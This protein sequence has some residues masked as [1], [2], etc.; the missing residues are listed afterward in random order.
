M[1]KIIEKT[2]D[3][4][5]RTENLDPHNMSAWEL[6]KAKFFYKPLSKD[7]GWWYTLGSLSL[8]LF[9]TQV[10]TGILLAGNYV[11][12]L[13]DAYNSVEHIQKEM[14]LGW[15]I[16]GVHHW[17]SHLMVLT[18]FIHLLR[19]FFHGGYKRPNQYIWVTGVFLL[20][21]TA[22][23]ALTGY[24]LP[25]SDRSYWA[26]TILAKVFEFL[27][28]IG[29][30]LANMVGGIQVGA[31]TLTRYG[32]FHM[33]LIPFLIVLV[34]ATHVLLIQLH[35]EKGPPPKEGVDVGT[36]PFFPYQLSK[37]A[38]ASFVMMAVLFLLA[39]YIGVPAD[40]PARPLAEI[41]SV[42]KPEWFIL[43]GYEILK[44]FEGKSIV[45]A[46]T[47]LPVVGI[48]AL[49]FL[50]FYD[51][52]RERAYTK[53]PLAIAT[54]FGAV[55]L[56]LY[57]TLIADVSSPLPGKFF[58][59]DRPLAVK[60][61]AG[62]ALFEKNVC[63]CCH[64]MEGV[65]MKNAPDLWKTASKRDAEYLRNLL[66]DPDKTLGKKGEMVTYHMDDAD[67]EALVSY[68]GSVDF[69]RY[70]SKLMDPSVFRSAHIIY[71]NEKAV[72]GADVKTRNQRIAALLQKNKRELKEKS[73]LAQTSS[74][75][76]A[77]IAT[78]FATNYK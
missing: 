33:I 76:I 54:G 52:N 12:T 47:V 37:D 72:A 17:G 13:A 38:I 23:M 7:I 22:L 56:V 67:L 16:R 15:L 14:T 19:A 39:R 24:I 78:Y 35:G 34:V 29:V 63:Y 45:F 59:P 2:E 48:A 11:P 8:F 51:K 31:L 36:Q 53:R 41:N 57:L 42:P 18:V 65:G 32:S 77:E 50:P 28:V 27:P 61:L 75:Q 62:L 55:I 58:A 44:M 43:F 66:K 26:A 20:F 21:L 46:L 68:L 73:P 6:L 70:K 74:E 64:S 3:V 71:R 25:W 69:M 30:W 49:L 1:E 5:G 60:E 10:V 40:P 4:N 9:I